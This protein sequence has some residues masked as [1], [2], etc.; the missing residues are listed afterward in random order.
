MTCSRRGQSRLGVK[1]DG[2]LEVLDGLKPAGDGGG[3]SRLRAQV[4]VAQLAH[5][6]GLRGLRQDETMLNWLIRTS[7]KNRLLVC[8]LA[9]AA[10]RYRRALA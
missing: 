5:G 2:Q 4:A 3:E 6:R 10:H 8:V 9:L 1:F 7:L